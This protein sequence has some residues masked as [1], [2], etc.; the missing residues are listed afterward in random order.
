[1]SSKLIITEDGCHSL[2]SDQFDVSYHSI[3]GALLETDTVFIDMG[4][5]YKYE[6]G[7][8]FIKIFEMGFG[9]GLNALRTLA[10]AESLD[11]KIEYTAIEAY[12]LGEEMYSQLNFYHILGLE[13]HLPFIKMHEATCGESI[14]ISPSFTFEKVI[15]KIEDYNASKNVDLIYYDAFAPATQSHL[16]EVPMMQKMYD[17]MV[18][19]G[20]LCTYCAKGSFKRT[21]KE[22]GFEVENVKGPGKK[23]EITRAI[24]K[25]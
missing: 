12:P 13:Y 11:V 14:S 21:L 17:M 4:L 20:I 7:K 10:V 5:R 3:N 9:T 22:V 6:Q 18:P 8:T 23:R 19:S 2:I 16:W 24:K 1:M 25:S 15:A